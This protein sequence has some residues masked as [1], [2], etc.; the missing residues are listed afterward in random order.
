MC[1]ADK[2]G[3]FFLTLFFLEKYLNII[4]YHHLSTSQILYFM[5]FYPTAPCR[6]IDVGGCK[7]IKDKNVKEVLTIVQNSG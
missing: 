3:V 7:K 2:S 4:I 5:L 1:K 6:F